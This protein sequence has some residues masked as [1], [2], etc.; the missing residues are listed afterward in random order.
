MINDWLQELQGKNKGKIDERVLLVEHLVEG[1]E[2][3]GTMV[4][5][6]AVRS[7]LAG[8]RLSVKPEAGL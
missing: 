4:L 5:L 1:V 3:A 8:I 7:L 6:I 2:E